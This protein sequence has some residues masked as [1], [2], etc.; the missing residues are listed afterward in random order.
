MLFSSLTFICV[1]LPVA[2]LLS[3]ALPGMRAKNVLL[4]VASLLFYA[5]G[6]PLYILL[7]LASALVNYGF[8]LLVGKLGER[9]G[10]EAGELFGG[11]E[12]RRANESRSESSHGRYRRFALAGAIVFN[13]GMLGVFKYA[14]ML[15]GSV[16]VL[17]GLG[18]PLP[19]ILLPVGISFY[20][21]QAL[22][23]VIDV[24]RGEVQA[25]RNFARVLLFISF[26]PQLIAGPIIKYHDVETQLAQ[27]TVTLQG[28]ATGLRR[29]AIGLGKKVLIADCMGVVADSVFG[30]P[31]ASVNIAAAWLAAIAFMLQIYFDFSGYSDMALGLA[32]MFGFTYKE[33]FRYPYVSHSIQEFWRRWHISLSTWFK[34][35]VYI[36]L[37]GNRK[38]KARAALNRVAV[39]FLC[40]LWHG[41]SWTFVVWGLF[42]GL[43]LLLEQYVPLKRA[44]RLLGWLYTALVVCF[45]FVLFR[46]ESF[47]QALYFMGQMLGGLHFDEASVALALRQCTPLF[48]FTLVA[49]IIAATPLKSFVE[50]YLAER[51]ART[52]GVTQACGYGACFVI[53]ALSMLA[54]SGGVYNPF[55]YFR[56]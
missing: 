7:M 12:A 29:F 54:M 1:F 17:A 15:V 23:Y 20:T 18:L 55:I 50:R 22:S 53:F 26:F 38:G 40:G 28:V 14:D 33:N 34:E 46:A 30:A 56:F 27:R 19:H 16:D 43:F 2:F 41:A 9:A 45:S 6:E 24:Y 44:P 13:V 5:Y 31:L 48:L 25:Q 47:E 21:F 49:G 3:L 8:G 4:I 39:F 52:R 37:G 32:R 11:R 35:Y 42:H 36:P 51:S 10:E